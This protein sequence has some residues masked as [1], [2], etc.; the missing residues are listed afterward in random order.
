M[1]TP[2]KVISYFRRH[3][4]CLNDSKIKLAIHAY[5]LGHQDAILVNND[6]K[7]ED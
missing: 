5:N 3:D 7:D 6:I 4:W 1:K 2:Q